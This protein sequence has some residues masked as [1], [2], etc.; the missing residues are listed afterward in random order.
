MTDYSLLRITKSKV[1]G[2]NVTIG[3]LGALTDLSLEEA[4]NIIKA[5]GASFSST[6]TKDITYALS[7]THNGRIFL[8]QYKLQ[9]FPE[10]EAQAEL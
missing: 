10:L 5:T 2:P 7:T 1:F 4:E 9:H 6:I 3:V 8:D